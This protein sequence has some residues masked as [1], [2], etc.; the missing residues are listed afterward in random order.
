MMVQVA[1]RA[2]ASGRSSKFLR[3]A[4]T[5][6]PKTSQGFAGRAVPDVVADASPTTGYEV[7]VDGES[8]VVGGTAA[9]APLWAGF[10]ALLNQGIGHNIGFFNEEL[11][12]RLGPASLFRII[13]QPVSNQEGSDTS[14]SPSQLSGW[15]ALTGWGSPDGQ[16][17]LDVLRRL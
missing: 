9:A 1:L 11:Y 15:N 6:V 13:E 2:G 5:G 17:L 14:N 3:E 4:N 16:K 8:M 7:E 10:I 12:T